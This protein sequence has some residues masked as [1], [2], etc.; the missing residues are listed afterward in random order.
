METWYAATSFSL[1][2]LAILTMV[3]I[4]REVFPLWKPEEQLRFGSIGRGQ[5]FLH[6]AAETEP[7]A[8]LGTNMSVHL[9]RVLNE[10]YSLGT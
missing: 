3:T 6:G 1:F 4:V 9:R 5:T 2:V 8:T 10:R 7:F